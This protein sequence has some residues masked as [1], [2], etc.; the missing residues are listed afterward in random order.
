MHDL[1]E[2]VLR[3]ADAVDARP[4]GDVLVDRLGERVRLLEHHADAGPQLHHVERRIVDVLLVEADLAGD[5][6][7][8]TVS[9][10]RLSERRKVHLPQPRRADEGHDRSVR[11]LTETFLGRAFRRSTR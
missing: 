9:F 11:R 10:M 5:M 3:A 7:R 1:V 4:V 8:R 2:L 6:R